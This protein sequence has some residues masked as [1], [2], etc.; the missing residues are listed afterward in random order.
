MFRV[1]IEGGE[2][3]DYQTLKAAVIGNRVQAVKL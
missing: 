2:I 3:V 1:F